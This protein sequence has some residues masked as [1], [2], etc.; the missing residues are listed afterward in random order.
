MAIDRLAFGGMVSNKALRLPPAWWVPMISNPPNDCYK[1]VPSTSNSHGLSQLTVC[2]QVT[3]KVWGPHTH[4]HS[5]T[6]TRPRHTLG[7]ATLVGYV[8]DLLVCAGRT[9]R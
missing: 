8:T 9:W 7:C 2:V 4:T 5:H 1:G 3:E 6:R